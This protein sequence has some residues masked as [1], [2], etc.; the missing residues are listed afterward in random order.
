V[1]NFTPWGLISFESNNEP[2][3][4]A[5]AYNGLE[6]RYRRWGRDQMKSGRLNGSGGWRR[7]L[8]AWLTLLT[9]GLAAC[10]GGDSSVPPVQ[11][12]V[13]ASETKLAAGAST[14]IALSQ[15]NAP[16][17]SPVNWTAFCTQADCG[18]V[19]P[20]STTDNGGTTYTAPAT[21]PPADLTVTITATSVT[22]PSVTASVTVTISSVAISLSLPNG[23]VPAGTSTPIT[24]T[25]VGDSGNQGVKWSI[26]C[27]T[28]PCGDV[29]PVTTASGTA[30]TYTAPAA[31]PAA[32][33]SVTITATSVANSVVSASVPITV[34]AIAIAINVTGSGTVPAGTSTQLTATVSYDQA[35]K[36]VTWTVQC[37]AASCG[38]L[39]AVSSGSGVAVTY[40]APPGTPTADLAVTVTATSLT[41]SAISASAGITVPAIGV[42]VSV[43][44]SASTDM[45]AGTSLGLT[46]TVSY[47]PAGKGVTWTVTCSAA[48]CGQV[49][50][51]SSASGQAVTYTAPPTPPPTDLPVTVTAQS[52]SAAASQGSVPITV[53]AVTVGISPLS[54]LVPLTATQQFI[55]TVG[56]DP[57][58]GGV[59]W[60]L[61]QSGTACPSV[62]GA[63]SPL[64]SANGAAVAYTAPT[65]LPANTTV[66]VKATSV[67]ESSISVSGTVIVT[68]GSVQLAPVDM[69]FF[70]VHSIRPPPQTATLTN[71]G[72]SPLT[73]GSISIGGTGVSHFSQTNTC[74][75]S[76][77]AGASCSITVSFIWNSRALGTAA[78]VLSIADSS[79]DSPQKINLTGSHTNSIPAL[80]HAAG[81]RETALAAPPPTGVSKVGTREMHLL[82]SRRANPYVAND[83]R[84]ELMV[85]FWYPMAGGAGVACTPANYTSPQVWE[86]FGTLL[87]MTLPQVVTNS[88][89]DAAAAAGPHPVVLLSHGF[90]GTSTDYT[91]LAEDLASRGYVVASI[92]HTNEAT[93][94]AFP[95]GRLEKGM[96]GSYLTNDWHSDAGTLGFAVA[97]RFAD[98]TFV[99][100]QLAVLNAAGNSSFS[101]RLD[102]SRIAIVGHSLGGLTAVRA[103]EDERRVKA[104]VLLDAVLPP[105][106]ASPVRQPV[107]HLAVGRQWNESDCNFWGSLGG[108]RLGVDLPGAEHLALSDAVWLLKGSVATGSTPET[109]IAATREYVAA[110]LDANLRGKDLQSLLA[111]VAAAPA[112]AVVTDTS[113]SVCHQP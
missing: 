70:K 21:A 31:T 24:A 97:V 29:S 47:D 85:R 99:L 112:G 18:Q 40:T 76:L 108:A 77:A 2:Y 72:H 36:G 27:P 5:P 82:D 64:T 4:D 107:L 95:D 110:F 61:L 9:A 66:T 12:T 51:V 49:S 62:C 30:A 45:T 6:I 13:S 100:D 28:A 65:S 91:Y 22:N 93:A 63:I 42:T 79:S 56:Y 98:L 109:L 34:P 17:G 73:I 67:T 15:V 54:A 1:A 101:G 23:V 41:N 87:G 14:Q 106:L 10:G 46:A 78:A 92:S 96:L 19:S 52:M 104:A 105:R 111:Q 38:I 58:A 81:I 90:T 71:T 43:N 39:S 94:V 113:Q 50:P 32:D 26:S 86:Y 102:L 60:Q 69:A 44:A 7:F 88:C 11:L 103:L 37:S 75:S 33:L 57:T 35:N 25:V 83:T 59:S 89:R 80:V 8:V 3:V 84:R 53:K 48:D 74:G 20:A 55:G 16:A 68:N